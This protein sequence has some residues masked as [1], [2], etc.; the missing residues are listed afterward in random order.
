ME[1]QYYEI[2][3][4]FSPIFNIAMALLKGRGYEDICNM[5]SSAKISVVNTEYDN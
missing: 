5:I 1:Q 3:S 2:P 4:N